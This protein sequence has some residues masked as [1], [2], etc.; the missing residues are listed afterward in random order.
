VDAAAGMAAGSATPKAIHGRPKKAGSTVAEAAA[1]AAGATMM[2]TATPRAVDAAAGTAAG[3]GIPKVTPEPL[4][5]GG[6]TGAASS[7]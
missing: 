2:M 4:R 3:S 1:T 7:D 6:S 5:K